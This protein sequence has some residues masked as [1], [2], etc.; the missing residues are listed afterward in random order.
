MGHGMATPRMQ[1]AECCCNERAAIGAS[2]GA[3]G[4][5]TLQQW[6]PVRSVVKFSLQ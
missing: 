5:V 6:Y 3:V 1:R 2:A 4:L